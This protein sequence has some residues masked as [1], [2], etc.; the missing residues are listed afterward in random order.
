M[1]FHNLVRVS[2]FDV[3][4][5]FHKNVP[6]LTAYQKQR[7][8]SEFFRMPPFFW[9]KKSPRGT[10]SFLWRLSI[11][12]YPF[13]LLALLVGLPFTF[14]VRGR[15]GYGSKFYENFHCAWVRKIGL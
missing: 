3:E 12:A 13:Y 11:I 7:L 2:E 1:T 4:E 14:L 9:Y 6:E 15:W 5:W 10:V 8:D